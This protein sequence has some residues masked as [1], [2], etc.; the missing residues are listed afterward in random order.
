MQHLHDEDPELWEVCPRLEIEPR[1]AW[2][3]YIFSNSR[4]LVI[5]LQIDLAFGDGLKII[6]KGFYDYFVIAKRIL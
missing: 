6:Y 3:Y 2:S 1:R 4:T 5:L